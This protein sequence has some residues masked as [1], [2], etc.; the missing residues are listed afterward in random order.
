[1][2]LTKQPQFTRNRGGG[3][4]LQGNLANNGGASNGPQLMRSL[5]AQ[6][7][8]KKDAGALN[9][10][11]GFPFKGEPVR[12]AMLLKFLLMEARTLH[13]IQETDHG[14]V[15]M[16]ADRCFTEE[17]FYFV[18]L[19][20]PLQPT[21]VA[22]E[23]EQAKRD[24]DSEISNWK[25]ATARLAT[26]NASHKS[27][28]DYF[29]LE[30]SG[31]LRKRLAP[32]Y[33]L[34][35]QTVLGVI[36]PRNVFKEFQRV[37]SIAGDVNTT[38]ADNQRLQTLLKPWDGRTMQAHE[39][40]SRFM[41]AARDDQAIPLPNGTVLDPLD[42]DNWTALETELASRLFYRL[43]T[44]HKAFVNFKMPQRYD[45]AIEKFIDS[46]NEYVTYSEKVQ[47]IIKECAKLDT[48]GEI[49][50][51]STRRRDRWTKPQ[52]SGS[53]VQQP[54]GG[55]AP[56]PAGIQKTVMPPSIKRL[57]RETHGLTNRDIHSASGEEQKTLII[58][59]I[60][61]QLAA[62][63]PVISG[64]DA[65]VTR[66]NCGVAAA[67]VDC[68]TCLEALLR[69]LSPVP[70]HGRVQQHSPVYTPQRVAA[71]MSAVSAPAG[72]SPALQ[73]IART[74]AA[75]SM[76]NAAVAGIPVK[77]KLNMIRAV[78][79]SATGELTRVLTDPVVAEVVAK[80]QERLRN[81]PSFVVDSGSEITGVCPEDMLRWQE[82][83]QAEFPEGYL[84]GQSCSGQT[85]TMLGDGATLSRWPRTTAILELTD[86]VLSVREFTGVS[87]NQDV[88]FPALSRGLPFGVVFADAQTGMVTDV[89]DADY[90]VVPEHQPHFARGDPWRLD[91][92]LRSVTKPVV[93]N[94]LDATEMV[95]QE[96][97]LAIVDSL[98]DQQLPLCD[99][100]FDVDT[101]E[102]Y[103]LP[104]SMSEA[105]H[106][107][108]AVD[109][110]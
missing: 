77:R 40:L 1:M 58:A 66:C 98:A 90:K 24:K 6:G 3:N 87:V 92:D 15:A 63:T 53:P 64:S 11:I 37:G 82:F 61:G 110:V 42:E 41:Q 30:A 76:S 91:V 5:R 57:V 31:W 95:G 67:V 4:Q 96:A 107:T 19:V 8:E 72:L 32:D 60:R 74:A 50:D 70:Q 27:F 109:R 51:G 80:T 68:R 85:L 55:P 89:G 97:G 86:R 79:R 83:T 105:L 81:H 12:V 22:G 54:V 35:L 29:S 9:D 78:R 26:R 65:S 14:D 59:A 56:S 84:K 38:I 23:D 99:D 33:W 47:A 52:P 104:E 101:G 108:D 44:Q 34:S 36:T 16:T 75:R 94:R 100:E 18:D 69:Q 49:W 46:P 73:N 10:F 28:W 43:I 106:E 7:G 93:V 2:N 62:P 45:E 102:W 13:V 103:A 71:A 25:L 17:D 48:Q 39:F 20:S 21:H 88:Y